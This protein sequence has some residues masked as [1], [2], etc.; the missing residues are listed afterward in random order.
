[1]PAPMRS[2]VVAFVIVTIATVA[3]VFFEDPNAQR[4]WPAIG[5]PV[6]P[7]VW[8]LVA[9]FG[10]PQAMGSVPRFLQ[11]IG[12]W[13]IALVMWWIVIEVCRRASG[14]VR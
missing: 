3:L 12:V 5:A 7:A 13:A 4:Q 1:M 10:G 2:L 14:F 6:V 8:V 9:F 11:A